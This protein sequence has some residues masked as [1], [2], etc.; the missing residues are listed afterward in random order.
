[1]SLS[2]LSVSS[3]IADLSPV[4]RTIFSIAIMLI[5]GYGMTRL[6]KLLKLPNTTAYLLVGIILASLHLVSDDVINGSQFLPDIALAFIS[7]S[8]GE[9]LKLDVLK[10]SGIKVLVITILESLFASILIFILTYFILGLSLPYALILSS[11]A[12]STAAAAIMM[13]IRQTGSKGDFVNTLLLIIAIDN[14]LAL[15]SYSIMISISSN[16]IAGTAFSLFFIIKPILIN[17]LVLVIGGLFGLFLVLL[18]KKR[19]TDNRLIISIALLFGFCGI[20]AILDISPLLGCM[21]MGIVYGNVSKDDKLFKQLN[22]FSPPILLL[23]FVR[24]GLTFDLSALGS[25]SATLGPTPLIVIAIL[26]FLIRI[27]GKYSGTFIG[28]LVTK[29]EKNIRNYL[30]MALIPQTSVA[31]GLV[32]LAHRTLATLGYGEE[33]I[34]LQSII[35][36]A[37]FIGEMI[38]PACAKLSLYLSKSYSN[39]IEELAPVE[40]QTPTGEKKN[41]V[42]ILIDRIKKIQET[43]PKHEFNEEETAYN[44]AIDEQNNYY[45]QYNNRHKNWRRK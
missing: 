29:K 43:I 21:S 14:I 38:G 35:L 30:G 39:N 12:S 42:D 45:M 1:M 5:G 8:T 9:Y 41:E 28:C 20:C 18:L 23:F 11:I 3:F 2:L 15:L 37:S 40:E 25:S 26:Y 27:I 31:I 32:A 10:R 44:E 19:S 36:A 16:I 34:A 7:F 4:A 17:I 24:S 22:Y 33:G 13:I 6:T